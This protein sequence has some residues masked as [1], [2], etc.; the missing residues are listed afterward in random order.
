MTLD[1]NA[2]PDPTWLP[3]AGLIGAVPYSVVG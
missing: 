3:V 1:Q 2:L